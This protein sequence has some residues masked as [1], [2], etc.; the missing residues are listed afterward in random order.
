M[1][2]KNKLHVINIYKLSTR[3]KMKIINHKTIKITSSAYFLR[4]R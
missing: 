1:K 4:T 2:I 3:Y